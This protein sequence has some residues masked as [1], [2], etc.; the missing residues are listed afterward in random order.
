MCVLFLIPLHYTEH[1]ACTEK[2]ESQ[3]F[4]STLFIS[5]RKN[6]EVKLN[7]VIIT[8]NK[9]EYLKQEI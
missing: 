3:S 7:I 1:N 4:Q 2:W 5:S 6:Y 9:V 8:V